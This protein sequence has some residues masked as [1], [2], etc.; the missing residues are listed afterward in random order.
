MGKTLKCFSFNRCSVHSESVFINLSSFEICPHNLV[1][2]PHNWCIYCFFRTLSDDKWNALSFIIIVIYFLTARR[3]SNLWRRRLVE[4][5]MGWFWEDWVNLFVCPCCDWSEFFGFGFS[6]VMTFEIMNGC[7]PD[8]LS[9][10]LQSYVSTLFLHSATATSGSHIL[11]L[12]LRGPNFLSC[13]AQTFIKLLF[14]P[15][16]LPSCYRNVQ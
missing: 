14:P 1:C 11:H 12:H 15:I 6:S 8:Y 3:R 4:P 16:H 2:F 13:H 10:L 7:A 5:A 9:D